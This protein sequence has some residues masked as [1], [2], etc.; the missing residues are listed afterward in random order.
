VIFSNGCYSL[1]QGSAVRVATLRRVRQHL[2][3]R[4]RVIVSY[5]PAT[6]QSRIG[7][8]L[9]RTTARL[10]AGDWVPEPGDTFSRDLYVRGLIRYHHAFAPQEF[11]RECEAAELT[12]LA[13]ERFGEGYHFA[14]A[15]L[16]A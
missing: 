11:A 10:S 2:A 16:P 4:G 6:H 1:L 13:D 12:L 15:G 8:W 9:T 14:A 3:P 7:R 5:H